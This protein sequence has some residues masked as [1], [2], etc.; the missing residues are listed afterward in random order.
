MKTFCTLVIS[1][2]MTVSLSAQGPAKTTDT[3]YRA[4]TVVQADSLMTANTSNPDFIIIDVRTPTDYNNSRIYGAININYYDANFSA[5]IAALDHDKMYLLYCQAGSRS[6]AT[7]NMMQTQNFRE[8]YNM[9]GGINAWAGAGYPTIT[10]VGMADVEQSKPVF[11][12]YPTLFSNQV[13]VNSTSEMGL[14][15]I[16]DFSG[17]YIKSVEGIGNIEI[18]LSVFPSG[19]YFIS[20]I[21]GTQKSTK[22][23]IKQ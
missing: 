20:M 15:I 17:R 8:V 16:S 5:Q 9:L 14:F 21:V 6:T 22:K 3:I 23:I 7:Y 1:L 4:L 13:Y 12:V 19:I 10:T 18:D 2:L 11:E